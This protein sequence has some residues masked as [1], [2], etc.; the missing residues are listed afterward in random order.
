M[1]HL[2]RMLNSEVHN[3]LAIYVTDDGSDGDRTVNC[4][5]IDCCWDSVSL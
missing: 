1:L 4:T 5:Q 3:L 2:Q